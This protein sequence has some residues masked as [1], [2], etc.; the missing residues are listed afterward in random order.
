MKKSLS[1]LFHYVSNLFL[2]TNSKLIN[3]TNLIVVDWN[4][5]EVIVYQKTLNNY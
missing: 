2:F 5:I 1:G 3:L 4:N